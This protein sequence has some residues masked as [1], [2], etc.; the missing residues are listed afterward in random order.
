MIALLS[1]SILTTHGTFT[2]VPAT[3]EQARTIM[4]KGFTSFVGH[5]ATAEI[6]SE[7]LD[8]PVATS[9]EQYAQSHEDVA[10]IFKLKGR[11]AEGKILS[12]N[13]I[14]AIGY[15]FG[16]LTMIDMDALRKFEQRIGAGY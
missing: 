4:S 9:R 15:D 14:E 6:L 2:F 3:L 13:E 1:T 10:I 12:R 11:P 16:V 7:L 5:S 8:M